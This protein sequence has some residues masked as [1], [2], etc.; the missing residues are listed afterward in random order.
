[1]EKKTENEIENEEMT[2]EEAFAQ[3][4]ELT[5]KMEN[6]QTSLE[7]SFALYQRGMELLKLC[8]GKIDRVEKKM[9]QIDEDG[10]ISEF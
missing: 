5:R 1:M 4:D 6:S 9:L 7:D 2:I 8:S 10:I 3:L